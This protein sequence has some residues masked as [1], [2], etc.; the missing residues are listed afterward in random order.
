MSNGT[1]VSLRIDSPNGPI[2]S[3]VEVPDQENDKNYHQI[4]SSIKPT[5]GV[6]DLFIYFENKDLD[7][8][9]LQLDWIDLSK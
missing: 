3:E 9:L 4:P 1:K 5:Q 8:Q 7:N 6:H 2:I